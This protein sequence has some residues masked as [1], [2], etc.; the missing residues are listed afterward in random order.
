MRLTPV[1]IAWFKLVDPPSVLLATAAAGRVLSVSLLCRA[2]TSSPLVR[3]VPPIRTRLLPYPG[4]GAVMF[5]NLP[6]ESDESSRF[7]RHVF[8]PAA[9]GFIRI[10]E[11]LERHRAQQAKKK[12]EE[13][14][15][16]R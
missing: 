11:E 12:A 9:P 5:P 8:F 14:E 6:S 10:R 7:T 13:E 3:S 4:I 15:E 2:C 16:R 1:E